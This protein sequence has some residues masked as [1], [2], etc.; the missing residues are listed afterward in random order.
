MKFTRSTWSCFEPMGR[1]YNYSCPCCDK[2][3]AQ[4]DQISICNM[5]R[6]TFV[7]HFHQAMGRSA[8]DLLLEMRMSLA[9][10]QLR[11]SSLS[12]GEIAE[13]VG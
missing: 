6:A 4:S 9:A 5:S 7:R 12:T 3:P 10:K 2:R 13:A 1:L 8:S 11:Q